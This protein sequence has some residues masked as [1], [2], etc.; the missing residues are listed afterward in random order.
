MADE[1]E[2]TTPDD[3]GLPGLALVGRALAGGD[4]GVLGLR[5]PLRRVEVLGHHAGKRATLRLVTG[6]EVAIAKVFHR[7][8]ERLH[9]V[10]AAVADHPIAGVR[11][12][13]ILAFV[14]EA[15]LIVTDTFPARTLIDAVLSG[16]GA[17]A[18][19]LASHWLA[20]DGRRAMAMGR[21]VDPL[22]SC[23]R[24]AARA[25][26]F[27][28]RVEASRLT[29]LLERLA[30][31]VPRPSPPMLVHGSVR[32]LHVHDGGDAIGLVDWDG[33]RQ[34]PREFDVGTF[35]ATGVRLALEHPPLTAELE[36]ASAVVRARVDHVCDDE[37]LAFFESLAL[38]K[39]AGKLGQLPG[40]PPGALA[41]VIDRAGASLAPIARR[42]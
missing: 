25:D 36:A 12:A 11:A 34:G 6:D 13:R 9:R 27:A 16:E 3:P 35:L 33:Y 10:L 24:I 7:K 29:G 21:P 22:A 40:T 31:A 32:H 26:T 5:S 8:A 4:P 38:A 17:R 37:R 30:A 19:A 15:E 14:P 20:A 41:A 42:A 28:D 23:R 39:V 18:G 2:S 1:A